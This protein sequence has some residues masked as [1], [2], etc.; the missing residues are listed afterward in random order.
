MN[1]VKMNV[2][3]ETKLNQHFTGGY[4]SCAGSTQFPD[5]SSQSDFTCDLNKN[6]DFSHLPQEVPLKQLVSGSPNV[7]DQSL[8]DLK[9]TDEDGPMHDSTAYA[10]S[11]TFVIGVTI[12][13][14]L[15]IYVM[16]ILAIVKGVSASDHKRCTALSQRVLHDGGSS[17]D[18]AIAAALCLG[19]VH[20]HV[21]GIGGGGVMMVHD[22]QKNVTRVIH[23]Q[24]TAP[25]TLR[26]EMLPNV[27]QLKAGLQVGVPG[28][29]RGLHHA[30]S[31]Y[32]SLSWEDVVTRAAA[33]AKDGFNVSVSLA[34]AILKV[35]SE[36]LSQRFLDMF[37]PGGQALRAGSFVRMPGLAG[38]MEAGLWNFYEGNFSQELEDE[39][40]ANGGVLSRDD[41]SNY[42]VQVEQPVEGLYNEFITQVP[43][44]PSAGTALISALNLLEG[45]H[46]TENNNTENQTYQQIAEALKAA[47]AMASGLGDPKYNSSMTELLSDML[48]KSQTEAL[49]Q[50]IK[51]ST[52]RPLQTELMAGQVVVM[53]PDDIVVSLAS[54]LSRPFG[55][56][57]VTRSGVILNS[58]ILDFSWPNKTHEQLFTQQNNRVQPG[59]RPLSSLLPT[60][61]VPVWSKCGIY[62]AL[63][64]S[65]GQQS[66]SVITQ[67]LIHLLSLHEEKNSSLS[68]TRLHP[69]LKPKRVHADSEF[70]EEGVQFLDEKGHKVQGVKTNSVFQGVRRNK[71]TIS[72]ITLPP[73]SD[74]LL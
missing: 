43:P 22:I 54:S 59:K 40:Q 67:V 19:V 72:V 33:V 68:L 32:G 74:G 64:S 49:H 71:D 73:L 38:V 66:L 46:L 62:A 5:G 26:E 20:P 27:L 47:M 23:F 21:S 28:M 36:R 44:P 52:V 48:S 55:S 29:L 24:G 34:E 9:Q 2:S 1:T 41:I 12:A 53:G 61:V 30:H 39:V 18:A 63:S 42:S 69:K 16:G 6:H 37:L 58:L 70:P 3:S 35:K 45:F 4:K 31:L 17:V 65:G 50:R 57:I 15:H 56:R 11:I 60:I 51:Y 7:S 8:S 13:L 25:N 10:V 14:I